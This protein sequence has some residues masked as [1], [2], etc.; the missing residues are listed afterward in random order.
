[1]I[2]HFSYIL[3]QASIKDE[4]LKDV[5]SKQYQSF[6]NDAN[7][8]ELNSFGEGFAAGAALP[9]LLA[10]ASSGLINPSTHAKANKFKERVY[11]STL[12]F[13][14]AGLDKSKAKELATALDRAVTGSGIRGSSGQSLNKNLEKGIKSVLVQQLTGAAPLSE[15]MKDLTGTTR[16]GLRTY[17]DT[18]E[19]FRTGMANSNIAPKDRVNI[20]DGFAD[21]VMKRHFPELVG[22][23][24]SVIND[25]QYSDIL[26]IGKNVAKINKK[27][28]SNRRATLT[29]LGR[30]AKGNAL[31]PLIIGLA[32]GSAAVA[33]TKSK[34]KYKKELERRAYAKR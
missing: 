3:K 1:M 27:P 6:Q 11:H 16:S 33:N 15:G 26:D 28:F 4:Y 13:Q 31:T 17:T 10:L 29:R 22:N 8:K 9:S 23:K 18:I 32:G 14:Q 30:F 21:T 7:K 19:S 24:M 5:Q 25:K 12:A 2:D 20:A 34:K